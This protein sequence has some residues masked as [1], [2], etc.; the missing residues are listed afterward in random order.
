MCS[1]APEKYS[2]AAP[3]DSNGVKA[4][5]LPISGNLGNLGSL[6]IS[7]V[8]MAWPASVVLVLVRFLGEV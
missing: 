6:V 2:K 3:R 4:A 7:N 1:K 8:P 5:K